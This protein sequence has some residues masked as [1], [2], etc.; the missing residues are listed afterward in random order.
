MKRT[1]STWRPVA[2]TDADL[3]YLL[4]ELFR[5]EPAEAVQAA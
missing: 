3:S 2:F 5:P 1:Q 4:R